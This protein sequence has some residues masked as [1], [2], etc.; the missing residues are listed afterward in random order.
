MFYGSFWTKGKS[1][2]ISPL[3]WE[4]LPIP[5]PNEWL[6][7]ALLAADIFL[8]LL[9]FFALMGLILFFFMLTYLWNNPTEIPLL[10]GQILGTI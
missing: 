6:Y 9:I 4:P 7:I 2:L 5:L 3:S 10:F 1:K 8:V